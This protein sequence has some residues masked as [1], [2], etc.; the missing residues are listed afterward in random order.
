[1]VKGVSIKFKSYQET[2]PKLLDLI[3]LKS[4]LKKHSKI[5]LK[6]TLKNATSVN[7]NPEFAEEVLKFCIE[8]KVPD[9]KIFIAEGSDGEDTTEL[10]ELAGYRKLAEKYPVGL[11]DLNNAETES[12]SGD[13]LAFSS[14]MYP[15]LL[16][17]SFVISIP[18][19][20]MDQE[21]E[22]SGSLANMLG[23]FPA[24]HYKGLFSSNKNKIRKSPM[25]HV[26]HDITKCKMPELALI[27]ASEFGA[28]LAG[29]PLEMDKQAARFLDRNWEDVD[30]LNIIDK[31][32]VQAEEIQEQQKDILT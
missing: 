2:I 22:I 16:L 27:D 29:Q 19:I 12:V 24:K 18:R 5:V 17:D 20:G 10:F 3:N 6:P 30:H 32:L 28:I 23:A 14:I 8:H 11:I 31:T 26:V 7:T 9:A 1:M 13:F 4:E 21:T 15:K 25:E